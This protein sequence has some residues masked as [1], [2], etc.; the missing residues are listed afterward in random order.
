MAK[1]TVVIDPGH[2]GA[3]M[4]GNSSPNNATSPSGVLEKN[5]TL[6][7][8]FLL[9]EALAE[10]AHVGNH[11]VEVVMTR[12]AD[13]NLG[14]NARAN[15]AKANDADLFLSIHCNASDNHNARG[16][17]T[18]IRP[19]AVNPNHAADKAFAARIQRAVLGAIQAHDPNTKDRKVKEKPL[20]VLR[21]DQLAKKTRACLVELEFIDVGVVDVLLNVGPNSPQVRSDIAK[22]IAGAIIQELAG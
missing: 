18:W 12:E 5:V 15:V 19:K 1:G 11:D 9:R 2:G 14:L 7:V 21:D 3:T 4:I 6:R 20:G 13:V 8:G 22:A 10:A 16:V 17:E